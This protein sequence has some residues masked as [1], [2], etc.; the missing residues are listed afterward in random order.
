MQFV[1]KSSK[2]AHCGKEKRV[3]FVENTRYGNDYLRKQA[4]GLFSL[5]PAI[6][7]VPRDASAERGYEI[8][9]V[10][11]SVRPSVRP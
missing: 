3:I 11:L 7:F 1:D 9:F 6:L 8:A 2:V 5:F 10:C 4:N